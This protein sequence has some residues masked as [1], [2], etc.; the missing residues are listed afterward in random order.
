MSG[1]VQPSD[2]DMESRLLDAAM[3]D[4]ETLRCIIRLLLALEMGDHVN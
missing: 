3:E 4:E 2:T 1:N